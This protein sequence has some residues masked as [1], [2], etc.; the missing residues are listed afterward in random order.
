MAVKTHA[1]GEGAFLEMLSIQ[2]SMLGSLLATRP[3]LVLVRLT[4]LGVY[5][6]E[7]E[8][9]QGARNSVAS[10]FIR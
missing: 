3:L 1:L 6:D 5:R 10:Q 4:L 9:C 7:R 8:R 2:W